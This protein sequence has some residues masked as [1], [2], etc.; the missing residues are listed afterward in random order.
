MRFRFDVPARLLVAPLLAVWLLTAGGCGFFSSDGEPLPGVY[1]TVEFRIQTTDGDVIDVGEAGASLGMTLREDGSVEQGQLRIPA[2]LQGSEG[3]MDEPFAGT[4]VRNGE[5]VT[6]DFEGALATD[7]FN[8]GTPLAEVRWT[9]YENDAR[10]GA[11]ADGYVLF[12]E[13]A[14]ALD[15]E[16]N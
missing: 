1:E 11:D 4:Y 7:Y 5:Q 2:D 12:L 13:K 9:F 16:E 8:T 15:E 14:S 10:L 3:N 6:F